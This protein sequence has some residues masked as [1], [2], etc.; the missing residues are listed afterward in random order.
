MTTASA[1]PVLDFPNATMHRNLSAAALIEMAIRR[2]EG[3]LASNGA[4]VCDT[5]ERQVP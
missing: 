4:L 5:G 2:G 1:V 3:V